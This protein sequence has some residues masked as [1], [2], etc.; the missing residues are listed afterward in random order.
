MERDDGESGVELLIHKNAPLPAPGSHEFETTVA[1]DPAD[2]RDA[3]HVFVV[4]GESPKAERNRKVA[5]IT[6]S[7]RDVGRRVPAGSPLAVRL[8]VSESRLLTVQAYLPLTDQ[9]FSASLQYEHDDRGVDELAAAAVDERTRVT[10]LSAELSAELPAEL[11][12]EL[13]DRIGDAERQMARAEHDADARQAVLRDVQFVQRRLDEV[14]R[15]QEAPR[16][17]AATREAAELCAAVVMDGGDEGQR[18]RWRALADELEIAAAR[19][20]TR[21]LRAIEA[22]FGRLR[23]EVLFAQPLFW[24]QYFRHLEAR[25]DWYDSVAASAQLA[26]GRRLIEREDLTELPEVV[27]ALAR[28][29]PDNATSPWGRIGIIRRGG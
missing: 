1:L 25:N 4:E 26:R 8:E 2:E 20:S 5:D 29:L 9:T 11:A 12:R 24:V 3:I 17:E 10:E 13:H 16:A 14:E 15:A 18:A 27:R 19:G 7:G 22:R 6:I 28:L 21:E 23:V